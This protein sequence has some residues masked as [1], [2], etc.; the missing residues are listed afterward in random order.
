MPDI[1]GLHLMV[2]LSKVRVL[3]LTGA[4]NPKLVLAICQ[5]IDLSKLTS[6]TINEYNVWQ[7]LLTEVLA[8]VRRAI[9]GVDPWDWS[10]LFRQSAETHEMVTDCCAETLM[11]NMGL[12][13]I[14]K[15]CQSLQHLSMSLVWQPEKRDGVSWLW[16]DLS[17]AY[18]WAE[19]QDLIMA[20]KKTLRTLHI[21]LVYLKGEEAMEQ[22]TLEGPRV[23]D[24]YFARICILAKQTWP[25]L[26]RVELEGIGS[27]LMDPSG[28]YL[29]KGEGEQ[30]FT[31]IRPRL[32]E[33]ELLDVIRGVIGP[34]AELVVSNECKSMNHID[35]PRDA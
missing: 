30:I 7:C 26:E 8:S 19:L 24:I 14:S 2:G 6:L 22:E 17:A 18:M 5:Q 31:R 28:R 32:L 27:W 3:D 20:N 10:W 13:L 9:P 15:D 34:H 23:L 35:L 16:M 29:N 21:G 11:Q 12:E 4:L 25:R 33:K 1:P